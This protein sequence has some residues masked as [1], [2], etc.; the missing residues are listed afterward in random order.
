MKK[1]ILAALSLALLPFPALAAGDPVELSAKT[2]IEWR[3][4]EK[5]YVATGGA[6]VKR[7]DMRLAAENLVAEYR[8]NTGGGTDVFRIT[9]TDNVRFAKKDTRASAGKI[10]YLVDEK[11][12][13]LTGAP[14]LLETASS[15]ITA[16]RSIA[17]DDGAGTAD[18]IGDAR[19]ERKNDKTVMTADRMHARLEKGPSGTEDLSEILAEGGVALVTSKLAALADSATYNAARDEATLTGHVRIT[20]DDSQ[21]NGDA[22]VISLGSGDSRILSSGGDDGRVRALFLPKAATEA[23]P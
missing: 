3:K 11:T 2:A 13:L 18:I 7:G 19:I 4:S 17:F 21:L 9:A 15:R 10:V 12:A 20:R 16:S 14:L 23:V 6:E 22:A 5:S 8:D 1:H